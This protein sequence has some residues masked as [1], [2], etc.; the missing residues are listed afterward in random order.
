MQET[1]RVPPS[2]LT[3]EYPFL[4][5]NGGVPSLPETPQPTLRTRFF[6]SRLGRTLVGGLAGA[7]MLSGTAV[8]IAPEAE[9]TETPLIYSVVNA[10]EGVYSRNSPHTE[11]TPR[12]D[13]QGAYNGDYVELMCGFTEGEPVG[14][15]DNT[16]W[17]RVRGVTRSDQPSFWISDYH[18][19]NENV[20]RSPGELA[21]WEPEC[22]AEGNLQ[23]GLKP[24]E[25]DAEPMP[26]QLPQQQKSCYFNLRWLKRNLTF[27]YDG[28]RYYGNAWQAAK[29]WTDLD[30]GFRITPAPEG[31]KGDI[32]FKDVDIDKGPLFHGR[33]AIK[34]AIGSEDS[35]TD[36]PIFPEPID[37]SVTI[38]VNKYTIEDYPQKN[39]RL[40]DKGRTYALG[41]EIGHVLGLAH[42]D[43]TTNLDSKEKTC[44]LDMSNTNSIMKEGKTDTNVSDLPFSTPQPYDKM[45]LEKLYNGHGIDDVRIQ[46]VW[47]ALRKILSWGPFFS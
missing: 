12:I 24:E 15:N 47:L 33:A 4:Y 25:P 8:G 18:V 43:R 23:L 34:E 6:V 26:K 41:H 11:D 10:P 46:N 21:P 44:N 35:F 3:S 32:V 22:D 20:E 39:I 36:V 38:F 14:P 2:S 1:M 37:K 28:G 45:A 29:N 16:L 19:T 27:S 13:G 42:P 31:Q 9:A 17:H 7:S 5:T 40:N 30:A